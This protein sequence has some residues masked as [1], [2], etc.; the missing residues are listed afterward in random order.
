MYSTLPEA[1]V[2]YSSGR[3]IAGLLLSRYT[4][5]L[6]YLL[7]K[8]RRRLTGPVTAPRPVP[9]DEALATDLAGSDLWL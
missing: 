6:R 3:I 5:N 1:W 7:Q 4:P 8:R 2:M 9:I